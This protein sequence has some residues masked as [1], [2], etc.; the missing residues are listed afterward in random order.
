LGKKANRQIAKVIK[1]MWHHINCI[2]EV[3][4]TKL[5]GAEKRQAHKKALDGSP[6]PHNTL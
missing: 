4:Y 3:L 6:A 5:R 2:G 1:Q